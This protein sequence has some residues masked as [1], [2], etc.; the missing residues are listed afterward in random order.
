MAPGFYDIVVGT[1]ALFCSSLHMGDV[2]F[3]T[4]LPNASLVSVVA[5]RHGCIDESGEEC[6]Y[7][8]RLILAAGSLGRN[9][10]SV[11]KYDVC[12]DA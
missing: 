12:R 3:R 5:C 8:R 11:E 1:R 6:F 4:K 10:R 2:A 7:L 9:S